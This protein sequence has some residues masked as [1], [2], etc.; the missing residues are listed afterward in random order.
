MALTVNPLSPNEYTEVHRQ[1]G[2]E[3][4][5]TT[6][7]PFSDVLKKEKEQV[8]KASASSAQ[9]TQA[10]SRVERPS[11]GIAVTNGTAGTV[12]ADGILTTTLDDIFKR[13]SEKFGVSYEYLVAVA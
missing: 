12:S 9:Q 5:K 11:D 1:G 10:A 13:A 2:R 7:T 6:I 3:A 4:A 8:E